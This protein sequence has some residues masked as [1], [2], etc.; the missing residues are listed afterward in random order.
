M[1][2]PQA[3]YAMSFLSVRLNLAENWDAE[4][5]HF[6]NAPI[7]QGGDMTFLGSKSMKIR[8]SSPVI[9]DPKMEAKY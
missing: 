4:K 1:E 6:L 5:V 9:G 8:I 7:S 3:M 2:V